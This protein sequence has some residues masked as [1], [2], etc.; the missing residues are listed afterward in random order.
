MKPIEQLSTAW[1]WNHHPFWARAG[2]RPVGAYS[3]FVTFPRCLEEAN[4]ALMIDLR[5]T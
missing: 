2:N 4:E 1:L 5:L 3:L